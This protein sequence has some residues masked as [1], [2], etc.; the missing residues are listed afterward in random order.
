[1][2]KV[3]LFIF[4]NFRIFGLPLL[5]IAGLVM[6]IRT[7]RAGSTPNPITLPISEPA[8]SS[9]DSSVAGAGIVEAKGE[10]IE[11]AS[12]ISGVV[13]EVFVHVGQKVNLGDPLFVIDTREVQ[14]QLMIKR[15]ALEV[16]KAQLQDFESQYQFLQK[17]SDKRAVSADEVAKRKNAV[18]IALAKRQEAQDSLQ[19]T[20]VELARHTVIAPLAGE[21]LKIDIRPGEFAAAQVMTKPLML[22][23]QTDSLWVR[24]DIDENDSWR[25]KAGTKARATLRGNSNIGAD[26]KFVR[27]EPYI[28]PK[29]SLTGENAERVDTRVLQIIYEFDPAKFPA[30][31]GQLVDVFI[32]AET[33][34]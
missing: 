24:V 16:S 4:D 31:V 5:A 19:A 3:L 9:F 30:F 34:V 13:A 26:L 18:S 7:V 17:V 11:I 8:K 22:M 27:F 21:I 6:G 15:A 2:K 23:G 29:K 14:A 12:H 25:I 10:N 32:E 28:V 20:E 1:M 33:H